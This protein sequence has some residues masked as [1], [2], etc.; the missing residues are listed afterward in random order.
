MLSEPRPEPR[1][2]WQPRQV[3]RPSPAPEP[4]NV[5]HVT[6]LPASMLTRQFAAHVADYKRDRASIR[7]CLEVLA[8]EAGA[9][10]GRLQKQVNE[11]TAQI[12]ALKAANDEMRGGNQFASCATAEKPT[13]RKSAT[14]I[15]G[16]LS[17][18][19]AVN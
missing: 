5:S 12:D 18:R 4:S 7:E 6:H 3:E 14:Q 19:A 17:D 15:E 8:D 13:A 16:S 10:C 2:G 1:T 11:L 9:T